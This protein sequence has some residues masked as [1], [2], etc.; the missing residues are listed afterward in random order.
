MKITI[1]ACLLKIHM[2][3]LFLLCGAVCN[4]HAAQLID[5]SILDKDYLIVHLSDGEVIH[6]EGSTG[7][8][9]LLVPVEVTD[10]LSIRG[11][12]D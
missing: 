7:E 5:V 6:H 3:L 4:V 1:S 11:I 10:R 2:A 12:G 9:W 8:E